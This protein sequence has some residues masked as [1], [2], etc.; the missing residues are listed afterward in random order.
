MAAVAP[1]NSMISCL[2]NV[3]RMDHD[4]FLT[5]LSAPRHARFKLVSL[6]AFN[7][8]IARVREVVNEPMLGRI[9][10]Q[11]WRETIRELEKGDVRGH[12]V[13]AGL[14][15]AFD[16]HEIDLSGLESLIDARERDLDDEPFANI[17]ALE[18]YCDETSSR[19]IGLAVGALDNENLATTS[20]IIRSAGIAYA[21][22]GLL[23]AL[24]MH[25]SQGRCYLPLD[26]LGRYDVDPHQIFS[27][28]NSA[29]LGNVI[30]EIAASARL[31]LDSARSM[32]GLVNRKTCA[33]YW[34]VSFCDA[35]LDKM[36]AP[37]FDPFRDPV[38][39]PAFLRQL[40]LSR[41]KLFGGF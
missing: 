19:L 40:R 8:E 1:E 12:E 14:S 41:K 13:A 16:R 2:E 18:T 20:Q 28:E 25:A 36:T 4:R 21:L 7:A 34:P 37:G 24:P 32:S 22:T 29:G 38:E 31:H 33:A 3:R 26:L 9:R 30:R 23:R 27:G 5:V 39:Y 11:W 15:D 17:T 6:Y 35:Y 10:L